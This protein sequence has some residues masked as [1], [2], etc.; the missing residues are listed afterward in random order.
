MLFHLAV[1]GS[2]IEMAISPMIQ[3]LMPLLSENRDSTISG[4]A[5]VLYAIIGKSGKSNKNRYNYAKKL[6]RIN[7]DYNKKISRK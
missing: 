4:Q 7:N 2:G 3:S 6:I 5:R 1:K